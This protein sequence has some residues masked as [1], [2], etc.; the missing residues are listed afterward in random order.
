MAFCMPQGTIQGLILR[1]SLCHIQCL[2]LKKKKKNFFLPITLKF[3]QLKT[4]YLHKPVKDQ[5]DKGG[6]SSWR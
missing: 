1:F 3:Y 6:K 4:A 2:I 5:K